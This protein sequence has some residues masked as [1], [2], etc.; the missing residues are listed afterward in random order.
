MNF[1]S[2]RRHFAAVCMAVP[3]GTRLRLER[4]HQCCDSEAETRHH[5]SEHVVSQEAQTPVHDLQRNVSIAQ[6]IRHL[7]E[8]RG[9]IARR[10]VQ[11]ARP[12]R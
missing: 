6:V 11:R 5:L 10:L 8:G 12:R 7:C 1:W 2:R 9:I 4:R 3:I